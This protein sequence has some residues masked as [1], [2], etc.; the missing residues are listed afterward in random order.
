MTFSQYIR[1]KSASLQIDG[2]DWEKFCEDLWDA[3]YE[4]GKEEGHKEGLEE[5]RS[6]SRE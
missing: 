5:G 1:G 4:E 3:A 2:E 6:E